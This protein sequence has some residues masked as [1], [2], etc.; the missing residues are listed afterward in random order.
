MNEP[1]IIIYTDGA[2]HGNPGPGAFAVILRYKNITKTIVKGFKKT[3]NNRM[4]LWGVIEGLKAI[5][6]KN[7]PIE[8]YSDSRYVINAINK[9][10]LQNWIKTD[11]KG[12]KNKDLWLEFFDIYQ[13]L[14]ISFFWIKGHNNNEYNEKC[15][16]LTQQCILNDELL[17]DIEYIKSTEK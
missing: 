7:I 11:F 14:N 4:E 1:K 15:D 10:W 12:K 3:T 9:S 16:Q 8:L 5:K 13:K 17:E 6:N 2:S